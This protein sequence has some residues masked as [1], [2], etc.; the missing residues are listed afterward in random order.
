MNRRVPL[1]AAAL[2]LLLGAPVIRAAPVAP[3]APPAAADQLIVNGGFEDPAEDD[4]RPP[5]WELE[6]GARNGGTAPLSL[7]EVDD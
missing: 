7:V 5:G 1:V 6:I 4:R 3:A 2:A